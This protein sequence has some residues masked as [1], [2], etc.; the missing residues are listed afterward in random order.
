MR[1]YWFEGRWPLFQ[2]RVDGAEQPFGTWLSRGH[3]ALGRRGARLWDCTENYYVKTL[4]HW[5]GEAQCDESDA[6]CV[7]GV[8]LAALEAS[9]RTLLDL[10][11]D[12]GSGKGGNFLLLITE[13]L[14]CV[15]NNRW[16]LGVPTSIPSLDLLHQHVSHNPSRACLTRTW[17]HSSASPHRS[18][19]S[20]RSSASSTT[21]APR[22]SL[23]RWACRRV[24][25]V[26]CPISR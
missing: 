6:D 19:S 8:G 17:H 26:R 20:R 4:S 25:A 3:C 14:R 16:V 15:P 7:D 18:P 23:R 24:H 1:R 12:G 21:T 11:F 9:K 10:G 22:P 2:K 5:T 13:W